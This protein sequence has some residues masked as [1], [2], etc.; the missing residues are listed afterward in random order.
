MRRSNTFDIGYRKDTSFCYIA[1]L[2]T[3]PYKTTKKLTARGGRK[4]HATRREG[5]HV[6]P[7]PSLSGPSILQQTQLSNAF[8]AR[9]P[10]AAPF[11]GQ[12][13]LRVGRAGV[14]WCTTD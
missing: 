1:P 11:V 10:A 3:T 9:A 8:T 7:A 12:G 6:Q 13:V 14:F 4:Q 5:A 2:A